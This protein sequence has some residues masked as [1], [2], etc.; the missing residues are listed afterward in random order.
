MR[1]PRQCKK[2][3]LAGCLGLLMVARATTGS[4][5]ETKTAS[6]ERFG[7]SNDKQ[8]VHRCLEDL[9]PSEQHRVRLIQLIEQLDHNRFAVRRQAQLALAKQQF[10]PDDILRRALGH[11]SLEVRSV[12]R[13][14][15][16]THSRQQ[17]EELLQTL[18]EV[19]EQH[20]V[21]G[22]ISPLLR[23]IEQNE[24][25]VNWDGAI[26]AARMTAQVA[27]RNQLEE[28]VKNSSPLVR[29]AGATS[30]YHLWGP[31]SFKLLK[32]LLE[33][34]DDRARLIGA[35]AYAN[36]GRRE[37]LVPF[38]AL[39]D[40][41]RFVV[42]WKSVVA[43]RSISGKEFGYQPAAEMLER[44][45]AVARWQQWLAT[46]R[47]RV[48][49]QGP[50]VLPAELVLF[51]GED[52]RGWQEFAE[53]RL[54]DR[55]RNWQAKDGVLRCGTGARGY[56]RTRESFR[57][58]RLKLQWRMLT[59]AG[60]SGVGL[61]MVAADGNE[62]ACLEVQLHTNNSGD[63]Y[64]IGG[65]VANAAGKKISFRAHKLQASNEK[66]IGQWNDMEIQ[67][68]KGEV[69]V[70][71]NGLLQNKASG[72]HQKPGRINLRN[73]GSVVEYRRITLLPLD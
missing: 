12:A 55:P 7:Y 43:L 58:Y 54:L 52:L 37:C 6:L 31:E 23:A 11:A 73:E 44:K 14:L 8:G 22:F 64:I 34:S 3:I 10:I 36:H 49:W 35:T 61:M 9:L 69:T 50:I 66:G 51:N 21:S 29:A 62:S 15:L 72:C 71:V 39:L 65:F 56:L 30:L 5:E 68:L 25:L 1:F 40:S 48:S 28:A 20:Q 2:W 57:N 26:N 13:R 67:V 47:D 33:D 46:N 16:T 60:D 70:K 27:D 59:G 63:L 18:L 17:R 38:V 42:R 53:G 45:A 19:I 24:S 32:P 41:E 4:D